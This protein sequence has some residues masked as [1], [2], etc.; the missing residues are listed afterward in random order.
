MRISKTCPTVLTTVF[1]S[2]ALAV[3]VWLVLVRLL[4]CGFILFF[5]GLAFPA[6]RAW[7]ER[8]RLGTWRAV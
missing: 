5:L 4:Q 7:A 1:P 8:K 2:H 3:Q 6:M